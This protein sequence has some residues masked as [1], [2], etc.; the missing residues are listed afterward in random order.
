MRKE[1]NKEPFSEDSVATLAEPVAVVQPAE[2]KPLVAKD[3][4]PLSAG[5]LRSWPGRAAPRPCSG[6]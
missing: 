5:R 4:V 3:K 6:H 1:K 2:V